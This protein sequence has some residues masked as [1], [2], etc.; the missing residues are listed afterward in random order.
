MPKKEWNQL[1]EA[2]KKLVDE[3]KKEDVEIGFEQY[4]KEEQED[5]MLLN[6][7]GWLLVVVTIWKDSPKGVGE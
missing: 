3:I 4:S 6:D 2:Q 1:S 5:L 7:W